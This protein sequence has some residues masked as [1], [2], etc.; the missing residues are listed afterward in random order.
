MWRKPR[1]LI[2]IF[3]ELEREFEEA[4]EGLLYGHSMWDSATGRLE[5]LTDVTETLDKVVVTVDLPMVRKEDIHLTVEEDYLKIEAPLERC[6]KY[7][8]WGI[9]R[10][11]EFRSFYKIL[12]LPTKVNPEE[13]KAKF[14]SGV[15][16]I[17]LPKTIKG[18]KIRVE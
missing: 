16:S 15:L 2:D 18:H 13:A 7:E 3:D 6:V 1:R 11:C 17:E 5:P 14:K 9:Q 8:R 4:F 12:K 10:G